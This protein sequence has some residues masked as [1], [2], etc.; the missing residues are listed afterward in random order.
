MWHRSNRSRSLDPS[1]SQSL[2]RSQSQRQRQ[3]PE[4]EPEPEP[5][6]EPEP[7]VVTLSMNRAERR[8]LE[9]RRRRHDKFVVPQGELPA[10]V[11]RPE[12]PP[13]KKPKPQRIEIITEDDP[14]DATD[15]IVDRHHEDTE[16]VLYR[17][18]EMYGEFNFRDTIL[19]QLD[20]YFVYLARMKRGDP[21]TYGFYQKMGATLLPYVN[22]NAHDRGGTM[23]EEPKPRRII[24]LPDWFHKT[25]PSFGCYVYGADPATEKFELASSD[26]LKKGYAMWVPKFMYFTKVASLP[27]TLQHISGGDTYTMTVYWDRPFD[28]KVKKTYGVPQEFGIF[29]SADGK[30]VQALRS[31][32]TSWIPIRHKISRSGQKRGKTFDIPKRAWHIPGEFDKWA[33]DMGEDPSAFLCSIFMEAVQRHELS[34]YSMVRVEVRKDDMV[35]VF[36]VNIH[37]TAYFFQDR[38][39][40]ITSDGKR[41]RIFHMVRAHQ[42]RDGSTIKFHFR[43]EREFAW[44]GYQVSISIPKR[45]HMDFSDFNVGAHDEYWWDKRSDFYDMPQLGERWAAEIKKGK[46]RSS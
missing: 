17:E 33:K 16:D 4:P 28:P 18:T 23:K 2:S 15:F 13:V 35:A 7:E 44:A 5:A 1:R 40:E 27:P 39:I 10:P 14:R 38:D 19:Q 12:K 26:K 11:E 22:T 21:Q 34:Q 9:R 3:Q 45:D 43:G 6:P 41:K 36:S 29:V 32:D 46:D 8:R 25:R 30:T 42:R 37:R 31:L 24:P 20:R